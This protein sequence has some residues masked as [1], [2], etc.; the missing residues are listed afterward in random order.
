[1]MEAFHREQLPLDGIMGLIQQG[2]GDGHLRVC[3][4]RI[5]TGFGG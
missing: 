1:M 3:E 4:H 2:A 5:P